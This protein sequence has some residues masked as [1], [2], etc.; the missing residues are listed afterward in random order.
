[1]FPNFQTDRT[2]QQGILLW[3]Q[4]ALSWLCQVHCG[5]KS[6]ACDI[7]CSHSMVK[8]LSLHGNELITPWETA[9]HYIG[10]SLTLHVK[11]L[12]TSWECAFHSMG[13]CLSFHGNI[14][15]TPWEC[16]YYSMG[17]CLSFHGNVP[18]TLWE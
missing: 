9:Y 15:F 3:W 10:I 18:V 8:S 6:S 5:S 17:I 11:E 12:I 14:P 2:E 7:I 16:A 13:M 1:M 4:V